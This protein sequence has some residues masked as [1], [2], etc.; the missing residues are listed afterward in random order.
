MKVQRDKFVATV[1]ENVPELHNNFN[2]AF[3][4]AP[5]NKKIIT[6]KRAFENK[7]F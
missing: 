2:Q 4:S 3:L 1:F 7:I 5:I 6:Q